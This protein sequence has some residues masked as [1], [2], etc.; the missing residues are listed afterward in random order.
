MSEGTVWKLNG[1]NHIA[2]RLCM[3]DNDLRYGRRAG[4]QYQ[5]HIAKLRNLA[6]LDDDVFGA[7]LGRRNLSRELLADLGED[8]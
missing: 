4:K 3:D 2:Y 1:N 8:L 5:A 7:S 6:A